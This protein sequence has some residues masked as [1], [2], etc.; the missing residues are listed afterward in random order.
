VQDA[1]Y[2]GAHGSTFGANPL[3]C[4]AGYA[5]LTTYQ[6]EGLIEHSAKMGQALLVML[7]EAIGERTIVREIRG[8]GLMVG[9]ELREKVAP[10]LK[11][12]MEDHGVIALPA[13]PQVLRLL[14]PLL[15]KQSELEIGVRAIAETLPR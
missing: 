7:Q 2:P 13:G 15:I 1:L 14:P 10:Y 6:Q 4:A 3:A 8:L 11:T 12:L 9:I 5:A